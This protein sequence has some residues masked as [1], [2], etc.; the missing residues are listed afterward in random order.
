MGHVVVDLTISNAS[1][2]ELAETVKAL[3]DT[4]ATSTVI[5]KHLAESLQLPVIGKRRV[6]T[7]TGEIELD[8]SYALVQIDGKNDV[9]SILISDTIDRVLIGVV[10]LENLALT[11]NPKTGELNEAELLWY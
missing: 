10:T 9:S 1:R 3:I 4:G 6:R 7:A 8:A 2:S 5:P 11:V